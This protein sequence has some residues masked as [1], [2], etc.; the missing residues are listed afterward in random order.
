MKLQKL[1]TYLNSVTLSDG[2]LDIKGVA[3]TNRLLGTIVKRLNGVNWLHDD[4]IRSIFSNNSKSAHLNK[5]EIQAT[6]SVPF[7][8]EK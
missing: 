4:Y 2:N 5:F 3:T 8:V 6:V 1:I 7:G